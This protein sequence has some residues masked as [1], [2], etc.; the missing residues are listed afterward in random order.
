MGDLKTIKFIVGKCKT[1]EIINVSNLK[2]SNK[3]F[4]ISIYNDGIIIERLYSKYNKNMSV[5]DQCILKL[6]Q[7]CSTV[8]S[9]IN[10]KPFNFR[11]IKIKNEKVFKTENLRYKKIINITKP[12]FPI[13]KFL[14]VKSIF[15]DTTFEY[16]VLSSYYGAMF[17]KNATDKLLKLWTTFNIIYNYNQKSQKDRQNY[18]KFLKE[19]GY[20]CLDKNDVK[21]IL[22][23]IS[24]TDES[25]N[26][27][28]EVLTLVKKIDSCAYEYSDEILL[29]SLFG[30]LFAYE[31]RCDLIHGSKV[32]N[33]YNFNI[34]GDKYI[35]LIIKQ[36]NDI[37]YKYIND[38]ILINN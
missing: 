25:Y 19:S 31:L 16:L 8:Y 24:I 14:Q 36:L 3:T 34:L 27:E 28:E 37:V 21:N 9:I 23:K 38:Y 30:V 32:S 6:V 12:I 17:T 18:E 20:Y 10:G 2:H 15:Y 7:H 26:Y 1:K 5:I 13:D 22:N 35:G 4:N 33:F 11:K 29:K